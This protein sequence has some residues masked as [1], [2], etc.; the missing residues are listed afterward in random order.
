MITNKQ[1]RMLLA[2]LI[3]LGISRTDAAQMANVICNLAVRN[4]EEFMVSRIKSFYTYAIKF[5]FVA[6]RAL[7]SFPPYVGF[8]M[9]RRNNIRLKVPKGPFSRLFTHY[10]VD[11]SLRAL[12]CYSWFKAKAASKTQLRKFYGSMTAVRTTDT[13]TLESIGAA[14]RRAFL[15]DIQNNGISRWSFNHERYHDESRHLGLTQAMVKSAYV[16]SDHGRIADARNDIVTRTPSLAS[17]IESETRR[18]PVMR[19]LMRTNNKFILETK[20]E[21]KTSALDHLWPLEWSPN[22]WLPFFPEGWTEPGKY[23]T[24]LPNQLLTGW[25][26]V[27]AAFGRA[28]DSQASREIEYATTPEDVVGKI[29]FI[30][31]GGYKLRAVANTA[32]LLQ[33]MSFVPSVNMWT[34]VKSLDGKGSYVYSQDEGMKAVQNMIRMS[35]GSGF[36]EDEIHSIDLSDATNNFP[37]EVQKH[38]ISLF[39]SPREVK[40]LEAIAKGAWAC[41]DGKYR[42]FVKG[43]PLGA[44][45]SFAAFHLTHYA[46]AA[47]AVRI[48]HPDTELTDRIAVVGDDIV[49]RG[50]TAASYY[51]QLLTHLDVPVSDNKCLVSFDTAEFLSKVITKDKIY[52]V[53][54]WRDV[55]MANM[56][57]L[58]QNDT[59]ILAWVKPHLRPVLQ[60]Y[61][62]LP[63]PLGQGKNSKGI[64]LLER[65]ND[66]L[67]QLWEDKYEENTGM[68]SPTPLAPTPSFTQLTADRLWMQGGSA[69][70]DMMAH[71]SKEVIRISGNVE[72]AL[73]ELAQGGLPHIAAAASKGLMSSKSL[74]EVARFQPHLQKAISKILN[75]GYCS[76]RP[77]NPIVPLRSVQRLYRKNNKKSNGL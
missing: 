69:T 70:S 53:P 40:L 20:I 62:S 59:S 57:Q 65:M 31:E 16:L 33:A 64:P 60:W 45:F 55:T 46:L 22:Y 21:S 2:R 38:I 9:I 36:V 75:E 13:Q 28:P 52:S 42:R 58:Y 35:R 68:Y 37:F 71:S 10:P 6:P 23:A 56:L 49:I 4:G 29:S 51:R 74:L 24:F 47:Y 76:G 17:W 73:L 11:I 3:E 44:F 1:K 12:K 50:R 19:D 48:T 66:D 5:F 43:Q 32:R 8:R 54:K 7:E 39:G 67:W 34:T 15:Y 72:Q 77:E 26:N 61:S 18:A 63:E 14:L 30:Q 41:P 25:A 27:K